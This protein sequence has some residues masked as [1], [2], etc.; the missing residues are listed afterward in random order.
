MLSLNFEDVAS[1]L[2]SPREGADRLFALGQPRLYDCF[3]Q[4][5]RPYINN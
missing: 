3:L 2:Q 5:L 1:K 4:G